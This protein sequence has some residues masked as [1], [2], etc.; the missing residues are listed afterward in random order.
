MITESYKS[1]NS[2]FTPSSEDIKA[3]YRVLDRNGDGTVTYGDIE[4]LCIRYLT[5]KQTVTNV[6]SVDEKVKKAGKKYA[7][8]VEA[9]LDVARRLFKRF[10][11]DG[12]GHL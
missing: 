9:K 1:F 3:Y 12:S 7:T 11:R 4:E 8:D 2:F 5:G 10:D 6:S